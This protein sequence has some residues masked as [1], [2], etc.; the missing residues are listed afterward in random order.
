[1]SEAS[2]P[3]GLLFPIS[4][5]LSHAFGVRGG[6]RISNSAAPAS[7]ED[8]TSH[9]IIPPN[10]QTKIRQQNKNKTGQRGSD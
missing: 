4:L 9:W 10:E 6:S 7:E 2:M 8:A 5:N 1:M 3:T